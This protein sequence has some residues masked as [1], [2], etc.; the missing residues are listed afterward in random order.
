MILHLENFYFKTVRIPPAACPN[1]SARAIKQ[2]EALNLAPRTIK[3]TLEILNPIFKEAIANRLIDFNPCIGI[4]IK[5]KKTKKL[6]LDATNQLEEI[7]K[8]IYYIFGNNPFY[9][10]FYLFAMQGRRKSEILKLK[11]ENIDFNNNKFLIL[12]TKNGEHQMFALPFNIKDEL[13]KFKN[14]YGYV[15]ESSI[16]DTHIA[17]VEKQTN[18]IKKIIPSFTLHYMRNVVVSAMAE[19]GIS[20]TL[21]S[22]ALGHNNT[23]TLSKYLTMSYMEGSKEA[24]NLIKQITNKATS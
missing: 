16:K 2:Q 11:W 23:N 8:A 5:L 1:K 17:N 6:V 22:S 3:T 20:A 18:K 13:L 24:N 14:D 12:D 10:S 21:M 15:Y 9:L 19:Q 4:S 7:L